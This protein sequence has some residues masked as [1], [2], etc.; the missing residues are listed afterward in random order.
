[1]LKAN[2]EKFFF[3][4]MGWGHNPPTQAYVYSYTGNVP[5][6]TSSI[7]VATEELLMVV[8]G[9]FNKSHCVIIDSESNNT[10]LFLKEEI[11]SNNFS[12]LYEINSAE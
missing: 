10:V 3:Q 8:N 9:D 6:N 11:S 2:A 1:M 5:A 7:A 4:D 12:F